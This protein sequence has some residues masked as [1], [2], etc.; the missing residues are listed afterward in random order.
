MNTDNT[1]DAAEPSPASDGSQPVA[2][3]VESCQCQ[4]VTLLREHADAYAQEIRATPIPLYRKQVL[5]E[6]EDEALW[7]VI[8]WFERPDP[9][10][11]T[12]IYGYKSV[13]ATLRGLMERLQ[14]N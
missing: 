3:L 5:T 1:R 7:M 10:N 9:E 11:E 6:S 12:M 2:W 14:C 4:L 13:L 8:E